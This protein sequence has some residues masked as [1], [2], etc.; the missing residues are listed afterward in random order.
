VR[1]GI[2]SEKEEALLNGR[3]AGPVPQENGPPKKPYSRPELVAYGTVAELTKSAV[4]SAHDVT[5]GKRYP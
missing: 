2:G 4:H 3:S 1:F 5:S